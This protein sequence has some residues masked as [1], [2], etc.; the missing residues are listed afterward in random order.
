MQPTLRL[1][2][3]SEATG[4]V[5][6]LYDRVKEVF[7]IPFVPNFIRAQAGRTDLLEPI[8]KCNEG[9]V[10]QEGKLPRPVKEMILMAVANANSCGYCETAHEVFCKALAVEPDTRKQI[11]QDLDHLRPGRIRDII[12]FAKKAAQL[13][14]NLV[15]EDFQR[16]RGHGITDEELQEI[17]SCAAWATF[18]NIIAETLRVPKD[19]E[20]GVALSTED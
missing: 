12:E 6:E 9:I 2:P 18:C 16:L 20:F 8:W 11:I 19:Q 17:V 13:P 7:Q 1:I 15:E 14:S 3:E 10:V 4:K 5:A